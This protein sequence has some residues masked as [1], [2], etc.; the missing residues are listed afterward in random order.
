MSQMNVEIIPEGVIYK[1]NREQ[2]LTVLLLKP[3]YSFYERY[4]TRRDACPL[5]LE[6]VAAELVA[7]GFNVIYL[8]ACMAAYDQFT[9]QADGGIRYGL[10]DDQLRG[11]LRQ[12]N[13]DIVGI[14]S[15]YS[16]QAG[17]V[18]Q[19]AKIVHEVY[20]HAIIIEGGGHATGAIDEV[21]STGVVDV[22][23][24]SEGM[25][26]F[27]E[28]CEGLES[29]SDPLSIKGISYRDEN[30]IIRHNP[31]GE[32]CQIL[33]S[34]APRLL[35]IPLHQM[36]ATS[37]HTGGTRGTQA[38]RHVYLMTSLGCPG[39]CR[40]CQSDLMSGLKTRFFSLERVETDVRRLAE[41][42][43]TELIVEDDQFLAN[44]PRAMQV[45]DIFQK[46]SMIWF[47]EGGVSMFKLMKPGHELTYRNLV[48]RMAETRC[49]R[50]YLAIESANP[51]S[52]RDS[53][54]PA[55]N[56]QAE[57]AEE[58]VRYITSKGV[59]AVG[60]FMIG[61]KSNGYE[62]TLKDMRCT[63]EYAK[64]LKAAGLAYVMLF[65]YTAL[66]GTAVYPALKPYVTHGY[67]SHE[68]A[69]LS[70]GGLTPEQLTEL[71]LK[72]MTEVNG[73]TCMSIA[74][75]TKNWGL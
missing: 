46:Y 33:D 7:K 10:T 29:D 53:H 74:N 3:F 4:E 41:T 8:D 25:I 51:Q 45:M 52:L 1:N 56:T 57:H 13:P 19:T 64:R 36:Y 62:E 11:V 55:I 28:F 38:G 63:V 30:G 15:L 35:E 21:L 69:G 24:R 5:G 70:V 22:V 67:T 58:I 34:L 47:E 9:P 26:T 32:F 49:Y 71:R 2:R 61:F 18:E 73:D 44:I 12:F 31:D 54:K 60:G 59:Q 20:P 50:F 39:H 43:A 72:W 17:N 14:T 48:D 27:T 16:N 37:E 65:I 68:R 23:V 66:P 42:G 6:M 40:F 75:G